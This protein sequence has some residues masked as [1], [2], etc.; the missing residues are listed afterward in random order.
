MV[1][2]FNFF[3]YAEN[4]IVE[5]CLSQAKDKRV[6]TLDDCMDDI[7]K[8]RHS[9]FCY[10]NDLR[11]RIGNELRLYYAS[12]SD[13]FT[14]MDS[15]C[16]VRNIEDLE[17]GRCHGGPGV[18][19]NDGSYF[20]ANRDIPFVNFYVN[21]YE[22][23]EIGNVGT[24]AVYRK[25]PFE[26]PTQMLDHTHFYVSCFGKFPKVDKIYWTHDYNKALAFDKPIWLF[27]GKPGCV[28]N[29]RIYHTT[30][31]LPFEVFKAQLDFSQGR[32]MEYVEV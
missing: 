4:P 10:E 17:M 21:V 22:N 30:D 23:N 11:I 5:Y 6:L 13:D 29:R 14:Y 19:H 9:R 18:F 8:L 3:D 15:D 7:M 25:Y 2:F 27:D 28:T 26:V 31:D 1:T 12:I 24:A 32:K 16:V 20:R